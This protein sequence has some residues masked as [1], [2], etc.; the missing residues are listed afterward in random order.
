MSLKPQANKPAEGGHD[1]GPLS[2]DTLANDIHTRD[3]LD[4]PIRPGEPITI[5]HSVSGARRA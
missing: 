2:E 3:E 4:L 5:L 1:Q